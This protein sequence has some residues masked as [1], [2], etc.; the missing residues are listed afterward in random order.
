MLVMEHSCNDI[1]GDGAGCS[2]VRRDTFA[3]DSKSGN[4]ADAADLPA[5]YDDGYGVIEIC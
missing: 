1:G 2:A 3:G 4:G 5:S